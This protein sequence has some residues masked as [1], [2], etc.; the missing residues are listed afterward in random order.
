MGLE[1]GTECGPSAA[2]ESAGVGEE[3]K[4]PLPD[5][6]AALD[7]VRGVR[8][9]DAK[10][11]VDKKVGMFVDFMKGAGLKA[12]CVSASGGIDSSVTLALMM[13]AK[14]RE[15]SSIERVMAIAQPISSTESIQNRAYEV[16]TS[17]AETFKSECEC[18][19][20]N[21]T[22]LHATLSGM[23]D[24]AVGIEG[25]GFAKGQLRSYMRTPVGYYVAQLLSQNGT[26]CVV[27][28]TGNYDEDGYLMYYCKAGDGVVDVQLIADLHKS[29]VFL[30]GQELGVPNSDWAHFPPSADL[31]EGQTDE[32][33]LGMSYD[34][35]ELYTE[36]LGLDEAGQTAMKA[37]FTAEGL[38]YFEEKAALADGVHRRN[39]HKANSPLN[40]NI[41]TTPFNL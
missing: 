14:T 9:F 6:Q 1:C 19:T 10:A 21:Q 11:W 38:A 37:T 32:D 18:V 34:F 20:V 22:E 31:W 26:P 5:L 3:P 15:G 23:V 27:M 28:G 29:E 16:T 41:M 33:E 40:I 17:L 25:G 13:A 30:V 24:K 7:G 36:Y 2:A 12:C 4:L 35:V 39:K 8:G